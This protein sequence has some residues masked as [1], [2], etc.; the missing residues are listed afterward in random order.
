MGS[1]PRAVHPD[2]ERA[3][4]MPYA[5]A[6]EVVRPERIYY[7]AGATAVPLYHKH[8]HDPVETTLP[9]DI[10]EQTRRVMANLKRVLDELDLTWRNVVRVTKY[11]TDMR[12]AD[13]VHAVINAEFGDWRPAATLL[14]VNNLSSPGARI[15]VDMVAAVSG[16]DA[17]P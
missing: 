14:C 12:E 8:P 4:E 9:D 6:I 17:V 7:I 11:V 16:A 5:P 2:P 13:A 3:A 10:T 15:E 1:L